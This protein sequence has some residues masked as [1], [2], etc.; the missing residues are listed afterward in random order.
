[1][2][3]L[4][5]D[6]RFPDAYAPPSVAANTAAAQEAREGAETAR[7]QAV[8]AQG[9]A[10]DAQQGA[11]Q[12]L[13]GVPAAV[14]GALASQVQAAQTAAND[15]G[16]ARNQAE[17][18]AGQA[19]TSAGNAA[20]SASDA[21]DAVNAV[22]AAVTSALST[23]FLRGNG[24]PVG[25][26]IPASAGVQ[27]V[28]L[29]ATNG[30]RIWISTGTTSN[31]WRVVDG[32]TGWRNVQTLLSNVAWS[33]SESSIFFEICRLGDA[34][35]IRFRQKALSSIVVPGV[36]VTLP[37]G[38]ASRDASMPIRVDFGSSLQSPN[39]VSRLRGFPSVVGNLDL[40]SGDSIAPGDWFGFSMQYRTNTSWPTTLPGTPA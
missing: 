26:I 17:T 34:C 38:F 40:I 18:F 19:Q 11:E 9:K 20:G 14:D 1:M 21:Q 4:G 36:L 12:A 27:Y 25:V 6:G 39:K 24:S 8:T 31:A 2:P 37:L 33:V 3:V 10:E 30:A 29:A 15:A 16:T 22:P 23:W 28:D 32:D 7:T 13:A 5:S 35:F